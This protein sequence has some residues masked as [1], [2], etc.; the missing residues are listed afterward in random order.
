MVSLPEALP[1]LIDAQRA[2]CPTGGAG[3]SPRSSTEQIGLTVKI[4]RPMAGDLD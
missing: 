1:P 3:Q 4:Y 2:A